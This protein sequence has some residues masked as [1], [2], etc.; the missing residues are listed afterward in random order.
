[1]EPR[2]KRISWA[3]KTMAK[4][5]EAD[6]IQP[7]FGIPFPADRLIIDKGELKCKLTPE[8]QQQL[9]TQE[10][11]DLVTLLTEQPAAEKI[12]P[13]DWMF[14]TP[15]WQKVLDLWTKAK[16]QVIFG[17]NRCITGDTPILCAKT[18]VERPVSS[19]RGVHHVFSH[20]K[21][22]V[23]KTTAA[24]P[25]VKAIL[26]IFHVSLGDGAS[27][28]ASPWH[29]VLDSNGIWRPLT[30]LSAGDGLFQHQSILDTSLQES[31]KDGPHSFRTLLDFRGNYSGYHHLCD[32]L[33]HEALENVREFFRQQDDVSKHTLSFGN[34]SRLLFAFASYLQQHNSDGWADTPLHSLILQLLHRLS[35]LDVQDQTLA[36]LVGTLCNVSCTLYKSTSP[37]PLDLMYVEGALRS[38]AESSL[39]LSIPESEEWGSLFDYVLAYNKILGGENIKSNTIT[40]IKYVGEEEVWDMEVPHTHN[41]Y[42]AGCFHHNSMKTSFASALN[43]DIMRKIPEAVTY[44]L[45]DNEERSN[46]INQAYLYNNLPLDLKNTQ[47]KRGKVTNL[48]YTQLKGFTNDACILP[49]QDGYE[50]GSACY[51]KNY[52]QYFN[53]PQSFEG[54][55]GHLIHADEEIP[56]P[57]FETLFGRLGDFH[58]RLILTVTTLQGYTPLVEDLMKGAETLEERFAPDVG[59]PLPTLQKCKTWPNTYIHYWWT[60][61]NP[62]IDAQEIVRSYANRPLDVR[63]ARLYGIPTKSAGA[64]FP[65]F[66]REANVIPH[67]DIPFIRDPKV[68]VTV[69]QGVDPGDGKPW[70][71]HWVGFTSDG[72]AYL[73]CEFPDF[74]SFGEWATPHQNAAKQPIGKKGPAQKPLGYGF[75]QWKEVILDIE[76]HHGL[77]PIVRWMDPYFSQQPQNKK[78]GQSTL[79]DEMAEVGMYFTAAITG[80]RG[81]EVGVPKINEYLDYDDTQPLSSTN[82]PKL[83]ISDRCENTIQCF[84]EYTGVIST[85]HWKDGVDPTRYILV[86]GSEFIPENPDNYGDST[87]GAY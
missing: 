85:E 31:L 3:N 79:I 54:L 71:M 15:A 60:K 28:R 14:I 27:F 39:G 65:K 86:S 19:I 51:F 42:A 26:P 5:T 21:G 40:S 4:L 37:S 59:K 67:H 47:K 6:S 49:A 12:N 52:S 10:V 34:T 75:N 82:K 58:G 69:Y 55:R 72:N 44:S 8:Q 62:F 57:L 1:M 30:E 7:S 48:T 35:T 53:N 22:D 18:G 66:S 56:F 76:K 77:T 17:G 73:F 29:V 81:I 61:D 43:L 68:P 11:E 83:Y 20:H 16:C 74:S 45:Q 64:Q 2:P 80:G 38:I 32:E 50:K 33:P 41:Y 24:Q 25:W 46:L 87:G 78:E 63:K 13:L 36:L 84:T 70:F 9:S 23:I